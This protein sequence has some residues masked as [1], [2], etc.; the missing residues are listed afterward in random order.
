MKKL[1]CAFFVVICLFALTS[2]NTDSKYTP[3][4][5]QLRTDV[6][7]GEGENYSLQIFAEQR[8]TPF[9]NDGSAGEK[10]NLLTVRVLNCSKPLKITISYSN[11]DLSADAE[12]NPHALSMTATFE[13]PS[14][15]Q[16]QVVANI[17]GEYSEQIEC[18]S[19]KNSDT[20]SPQTALN[21]VISEK[22]DFIASISENG[23]LK[24]EIY[25]RLLVEN[26]SNFYYIGF[27]QGSNKITAFLLDG[28]TGEIIAGKD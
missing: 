4:I 5:S 3:Y 1:F 9:I 18:V 20:I 2:C 12:Y 25:I 7:V 26:D 6:F 28:K 23:E 16:G 10:N 8:E 15:P 13:V 22:K 24:A 27:G 19:K 17:E 14:F 21:K 11:Q